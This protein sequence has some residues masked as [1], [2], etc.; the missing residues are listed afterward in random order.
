MV[1]NRW[2]Y[3]LFLIALFLIAFRSLDKAAWKEAVDGLI[4][5]SLTVLSIFTKISYGGLLV[6]AFLGFAILVRRKPAYF[7]SVLASAILFL[8]LVGWP[9]SWDFS[10]FLHD[11][12]LLGHAHAGLGLHG[13][14]VAYMYLSPHVCLFLM[15]AILSFATKFLSEEKLTISTLF[16]ASIV[17]FT[18]LAS[19][20]MILMTNSLD[21]FVPESPVLN[22]GSLIILAEII[23]NREIG[24]AAP[25]LIPSRLKLL[26][27]LLIAPGLL[28]VLTLGIQCRFS[29]A[30]ADV[31]LFRSAA[32]LSVLAFVPCYW[33]FVNRGLRELRPVT[34]IVAGCLAAFAIAGPVIARNIEGLL[35]ALDY[36]A[37]S[38]KLPANQIFQSG[39][40]KGIQISG[41]GGDAAIS[42][43]YVEK[44]EDGL[45]LIERT[46]SHEK[47]VA[48]LDFSD[49]FN[50][51]RSVKPPPGFPLCWDPG[52][53]FSTASAPDE[54]QIFRGAEVVMVPKRTASSDRKAWDALDQ[55]YGRYLR[56]H[57][58]LAGESQQWSL[59]EMK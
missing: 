22:I 21:G 6:A 56:V 59:Y 57:Y 4:A 35:I 37:G 43:T 16:H 5:G 51:A 48:D 28:L 15:L 38:R 30:P 36:K 26:R 18:Y 14:I 11:I 47:P 24:G 33:L 39:S 2:G 55:L 9:I 31:L 49:P 54:E 10:A 12:R 3:C 8:G 23:R 13:L 44:V 27:W 45:A 58:T 19:A 52:I 29:R 7:I 17:P 41:F 46:G 50:I 25:K 32:A 1:Y 40:L 53:T 34:L 42:T 20:L